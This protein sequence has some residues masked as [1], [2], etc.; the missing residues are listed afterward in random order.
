MTR[1]E[2]VPNFRCWLGT[3]VPTTSAPR[4][5]VTQLRTFRVRFGMS[6]VDPSGQV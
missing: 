5:L 2:D 4:P 6:Q 3:E 1:S